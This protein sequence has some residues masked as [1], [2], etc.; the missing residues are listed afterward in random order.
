MEAIAF[1]SLV[2]VSGA[3]LAAGFIRRISFLQLPF[4]T[5]AVFLGWVVPQLWQVRQNYGS[6]AADY[7]TLLHIF[8]IACLLA[9]VGAWHFGIRSGKR[10]SIRD[11]VTDETLLRI[12]IIITIIAWLMTFAI[13]MRA[14]EERAASTWSGPLAIMSFFLNLKVISLFLSLYLVLKRRSPLIV[15][16]LV[17]NVI[18]YVP[19]VLLLFRRRAMLEALTSVI[20]AL[21]FGRRILAPRALVAAAIPAGL[22]VVFAVGTLRNLG[23]VNTTQA[24][25]I[26]VAE[27]TSAD[28]W[29]TT[30][31]GGTD[32]APELTNALRIVRFSED[33]G[34]HTYGAASWDR[35]IQL[36][37]PGQLVGQVNKQSLM[38]DTDVPQEI[39]DA[40]NEENRVGSTPTGMGEAYLEFGFFGIIFFGA[41][42]FVTGRWWSRANR[43]SRTAMVFY[44]VGL[45]AA[46]LMP[47]AYAIYFFNSIG[48]HL[49]ILVILIAG[50]S[51]RRGSRRVVQQGVATPRVVRGGSYQRSA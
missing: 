12:C 11:A 48:L 5:A 51:E 19:T 36:W 1:W 2:L 42:G 20:L 45:P 21:W 35:I 40:Y 13:G 37:V 34:L 29:S 26:S 3:I 24:H 25:W 41:M 39:L 7:L 49:A 23:E 32:R 10:G 14:D 8:C 30:P 15:A 22:V 16:V 33:W 4:L 38:L 9:T 43:G 27:V 17:A 50:I 28:L 6:L 31:F 46:L 47:T 44:A 18:L